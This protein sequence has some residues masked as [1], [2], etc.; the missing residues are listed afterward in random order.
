MLGERSF[1]RPSTLNDGSNGLPQQGQSGSRPIISIRAGTVSSSLSNGRPRARL[2]SNMPERINLA[3]ARTGALATNSRRFRA[4]S[5]LW[6]WAYSC[7]R[8]GE[9]RSAFSRFHRPMYARAHGLHVRVNPSRHCGLGLKNS[10]VD[11]Y[12]LPQRPH[13]LIAPCSTKSRFW[14]NQ[15]DKFGVAA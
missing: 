2:R 11:G 13:F 10:T 12:S 4:C 14:G 7:R 6:R 3:R 8:L 5:S 15:T 9:I 1:F